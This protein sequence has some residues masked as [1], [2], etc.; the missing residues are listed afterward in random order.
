MKNFLAVL[1]TVGVLAAS[2]SVAYYYLY[3]LPQQNIKS[4]EDISAIRSV[5]APTPEQ[6]KIQ[7]QNYQKS[8]DAM[9]ARMNEYYNCVLENQKKSSVWLDQ[10]CPTDSSNPSSYLKAMDCRSDAIASAEYE[11]RFGCTSPF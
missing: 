8:M 2:G 5:V 1:V 6:Q 3:F 11:Q 9:N 7:Q 4:Q 10:K